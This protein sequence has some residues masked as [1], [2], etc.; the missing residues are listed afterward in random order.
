MAPLNE[1]DEALT[2]A[3]AAKL[4]ADPDELRQ[5]EG[6][7]LQAVPSNGKG[8]A[9]IKFDIDGVLRDVIASDEFTR[10]ER[11]NIGKTEIRVEDDRTYAERFAKDDIEVAKDRRLTAVVRN[12]HIQARNVRIIALIEPRVVSAAAQV[13]EH[14]LVPAS[15]VSRTPKINQKVPATRHKKKPELLLVNPE[16]PG[17]KALLLIRGHAI[18]LLRFFENRVPVHFSYR[19]ALMAQVDRCIARTGAVAT[20]GNEVVAILHERHLGPMLHSIRANA[21]LLTEQSCEEVVLA[22][23]D[24]IARDQPNTPVSANQRAKLGKKV[25]K[26][27]SQGARP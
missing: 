19:P 8:M 23:K 15:K 10:I 27:L 18:S 24:A 6:F 2:D 1:E 21:S 14:R 26:F 20:G 17:E 7:S 25:S 16:K 9:V 4:L 11:L 13:P 12:V 22:L 3:E 5:V